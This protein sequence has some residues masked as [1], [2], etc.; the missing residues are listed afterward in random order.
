MGVMRSLHQALGEK[1]QEKALLVSWSCGCGC[2]ERPSSPLFLPKLGSQRHGNRSAKSNR[3]FTK[4]RKE[5]LFTTYKNYGSDW[6]G[7]LLLFALDEHLSGGKFREKSCVRLSSVC[8]GS[9][10]GLT[11]HHVVIL[12][13]VPKHSTQN[14]GPHDLTVHLLDKL[15]ER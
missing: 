5:S 11:V 14:N 3:L 8:G 1:K 12:D 7:L 4:G 2:I 13:A 6:F 9:F 10:D 15:W